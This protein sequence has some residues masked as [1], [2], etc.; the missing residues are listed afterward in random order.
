MFFNKKYLSALLCLVISTSP[1]TAM[2]RNNSGSNNNGGGIDEL[3]RALKPEGVRRW[4]E[5]QEQGLTQQQADI[6]RAA[7]ATRQTQYETERATRAAQEAT[8]QAQYQADQERFR[9]QQRAYDAQIANARA[10]E[11][12]RKRERL[13][14]EDLNDQNQQARRLQQENVRHQNGLNEQREKAR[15]DK[16]TQA[17]T[18]K[19]TDQ[20]TRKRLDEKIKKEKKA[21]EEQIAKEKQARKERLEQEEKAHKERLE[22]ETEAKTV[23]AKAQ[24]RAQAEKDKE[25]FEFRQQNKDAYREQ[26]KEKHEFDKDTMRERV[27]EIF[28]GIFK[29]TDDPVR[30]KKVLT[31]VSTATALTAGGIYFFKHFWP[32]VRKKV[33]EK[34]FVPA[35]IDET[36]FGSK[37]LFGFWKKKK[38]VGPQ[39]KDLVYYPELGKQV[40]RTKYVLTNTKK[41]GGYYLN[42]LFYGEPGTGKTATARALARES[43]MDWAFMSG[44]NVQK[45]LKTG[46]AEER[47]KEVFSWAQKSKK[48]LILFIDEADAF[49]KDPNQDNMS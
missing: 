37:S 23:Q 18:A 26:E 41:N 30:M 16:E 40:E 6:L 1:L 45:L 25:M 42:Y 4:L 20:L 43:G 31:T 11:E 5:L 7:E 46:K 48:G 14:Q 29:F 10:N 19:I 15:L 44:G 24:A 21:Q 36:S 2:F 9:A 27:K 38:V 49:L 34:L 47:L 3:L 32:I 22:R 39:M 35:L 33:E 8:R 13:R 28:D 12:T 17:A